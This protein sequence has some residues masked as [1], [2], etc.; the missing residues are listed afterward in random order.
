MQLAALILNKT[1]YLEPLLEELLQAGIHGATVLDST[2]MMRVLSKNSDDLPMF[3]A[4]RQLFDPER[5]SSKTVLMVLEDEQVQVLRKAVKDV[6][7][8]LSQPDTG[9]LFALPVLFVDGMGAS[10]Q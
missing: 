3:G 4:L 5:T 10:A 7:G 8:G 9:I 2:G 6:T 1:E